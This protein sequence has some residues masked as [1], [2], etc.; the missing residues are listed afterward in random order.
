MKNKQRDILLQLQIKKEENSQI[1][2]P[3]DVLIHAVLNTINLNVLVLIYVNNSLIEL[4]KS[5]LSNIEKRSNHHENI[6]ALYEN[7]KL[8]LES[9]IEYYK[10]Q[11]IRKVLETLI[12]NLDDFYKRDFFNTFFYSKYSND[13]KSAIK[14]INY[15]KKEI[16]NE[17]L[18]EY[19][20]TGNTKYLQP[21]LKKNY[22]DFLAENI[23]GIWSMTPSFFYKKQLIGLLAKTKFQKLSF[24]ENHEV[25][26]Y[27]LACLIKKR[28]NVKTTKQFL[29]TVPK[30][31]RHFSILNLS[32]ELEFK[33]IEGEV[34][35]Y[36]D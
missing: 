3:Y 18:D 22:I 32:K 34:K 9:D 28:I 15:S 2:H 10:S 27:L 6:E 24:L 35:K 19:S 4:K 23:E 14:Y 36:L 20:K 11:R 17:L 26:L 16:H 30:N 7:L 12:V 33:D 8:T 29:D 13:K 31:K 21:L 5:I 1:P 25:D